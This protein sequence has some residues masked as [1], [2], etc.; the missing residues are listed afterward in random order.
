[1]SDR[2]GVERVLKKPAAVGDKKLLAD[3]FPKSGVVFYLGT[4]QSAGYP[5]LIAHGSVAAEVNFDRKEASI[6]L[7]YDGAFMK[8]TTKQ[9]KT[10]MEDSKG[11][12]AS[13]YEFRVQSADGT[14]VGAARQSLQFTADSITTD[15]IKG[16]YKSLKPKDSGPFEMKAVAQK[17]FHEF[18]Q[19]SGACSIQ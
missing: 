1:M 5:W 10:K 9:L 13:S 3:A 15:L 6:L 11:G 18:A 16:T 7:R 4:W 12:S 19:Q 14:S 8:G 17:Q 2:G